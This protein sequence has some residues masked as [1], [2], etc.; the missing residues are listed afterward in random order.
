M[1]IFLNISPTSNSLHLLGPQVEIR[2]SN[3]RFVVDEDDNGNFS[4]KGLSFQ[5]EDHT[6]TSEFIV[7]RRQILT[8]KH[9][10]ITKI[11]KIF[12][13]PNGHRHITYVFV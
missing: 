13:G 6:Y 10:P 8:Y 12:I 7:C 3:S 11:I 9:D 2:D 5:R 1:A 4:S